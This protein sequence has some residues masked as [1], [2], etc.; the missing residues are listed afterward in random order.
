VSDHSDDD[1]ND[2]D[3]RNDVDDRPDDVGA[4]PRTNLASG[5]AGNLH[6]VHSR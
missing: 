6:A 4:G 2:D 3:Q 5:A 1:E